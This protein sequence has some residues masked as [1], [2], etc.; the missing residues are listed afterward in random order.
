[1]YSPYRFIFNEE[2]GFYYF[3]TQSKIE[4]RCFFT[5][6]ESG[7]G[8]LPLDLSHEVYNFDL[9]RYT[10]GDS[11]KFD[12]NVSATVGVILNQFFDKNPYGIISYICDNTDSKGRKRQFSFAKWLKVFNREPK[13][14]LI[15]ASI[16]DTI[17]VGAVLI[18]SHPEKD[19]VYLYF[20]SQ[21]ES[22]E[23]EMHKTGEVSIFQS[24]S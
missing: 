10:K 9:I 8:T 17:Y 6:N 21:L 14:V 13:K 1:M 23:N 5:Q 19:K 24:S 16:L 11:V 20:Q 4:Y 12:R 22:I 7:N 15:R 18:S 3:H 2:E